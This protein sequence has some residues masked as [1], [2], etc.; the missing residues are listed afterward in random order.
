MRHLWL[1][2]FKF[3][4]LQFFSISALLCTGSSQNSVDKTQSFAYADNVKRIFYFQIISRL[5]GKCRERKEYIIMHH[6]D[7]IHKV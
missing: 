6:N 1:K 7:A 4:Y 5:Y 2:T 3:G